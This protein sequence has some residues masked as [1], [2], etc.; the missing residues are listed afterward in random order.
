MKV[1]QAQSAWRARRETG[2]CARPGARV[3]SPGALARGSG[4]AEPKAALAARQ[5]AP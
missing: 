3:A 5:V 4:T 2:H 1:R